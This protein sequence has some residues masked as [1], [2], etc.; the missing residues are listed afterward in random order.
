MH[1]AVGR[2]LA[3]GAVG[4]EGEPERLGLRAG[5]HRRDDRL[6]PGLR[7]RSAVVA[8]K[9][10]TTRNVRAMRPP[11]NWVPL[12]V[13]ETGG[14]PEITPAGGVRFRPPTRTRQAQTRSSG[15]RPEKPTPAA[16][17]R[18]VPSTPTR[19]RGRSGWAPATGI[20]VRGGGRVRPAR[21]PRVDHRHECLAGWPALRSPAPSLQSTMVST[22]SCNWTHAQHRLPT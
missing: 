2:P 17:D 9:S 5:V 15:T 21:P 11:E 12:D 18:Q 14:P 10:E 6:V 1:I 3:V 7:V 13:L 8:M 22:D 16:R 20:G 19:G 4:T